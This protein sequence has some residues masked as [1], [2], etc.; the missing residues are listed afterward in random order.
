MLSNLSVVSY[1]QNNGFNNIGNG[2]LPNSNLNGNSNGNS[3]IVVPTN[4]DCSGQVSTSDFADCLRRKS[5]IAN[6]GTTTTA[7]TNKPT[8]G[9]NSTRNTNA[10]RNLS[11]TKCTQTGKGQFDIAGGGK[12][13]KES[14]LSNANT[15]KILGANNNATTTNNRNTPTVINGSAN[16][17]TSI[18]NGVNKSTNGTNKTANKTTNSPQVV[19]G[20][21]NRNTTTNKPIT[22]NGANRNTTVANKTVNKT[23]NTKTTNKPIAVNTTK[24]TNGGGILGN[25]F[26]LFNRNS[27][28]KPTNS[29]YS[30]VGRKGTTSTTARSTLPKITAADLSCIQEGGDKGSQVYV[31]SN[32]AANPYNARRAANCTFANAIL[33]GEG[34]SQFPMT[35]AEPPMTI[36]LI[37]ARNS[38]NLTNCYGYAVNSWGNVQ[39][40]IRAKFAE[41]DGTYRPQPSAGSNS[42][43]MEN[44][45]WANVDSAVRRDG[46]KSTSP[47]A[48]CPVNHYKIFGYFT[49]SS[50]SFA[51]YHWVMQN[52]PGMDGKVR[53]SHKPGPTPARDVDSK[54]NVIR[55]PLQ[56]GLLYYPKTGLY[57]DFKQAYCVPCN[58]QID[59]VRLADVRAILQKPPTR[60]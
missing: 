42:E 47:S 3:N 50:S 37:N 31:N 18:T 10:G 23:T 28:S 36:P 25:I 2:N 59:P 39:D 55:D 45:T 15:R 52:R 35:G 44:F 43:M 46:L 53:F 29:G 19:N 54:G 56:P 20:T 24:S 38:K 6:T 13:I 14:N 11:S 5:G 8:I 1:A 57:Y 17:S 12:V 41:S 21:T 51:D 40:E 33:N 58:F 34:S 16:K 9:S 49:N 30:L 22:T 48:K 7:T 4:E 26:N 60:K 27:S 32:S